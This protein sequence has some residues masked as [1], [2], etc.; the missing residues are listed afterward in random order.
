MPDF[1]A[2]TGVV[3]SDGKLWMATIEFPRARVLSS[4]HYRRAEIDVLARSARTFRAQT[5]S[6]SVGRN[7][8]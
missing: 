4:S 5:S 7:H 8:I 6:L 2:V 1:G 3:E